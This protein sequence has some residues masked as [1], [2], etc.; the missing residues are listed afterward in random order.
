M[1]NKE[2]YI[3]RGISGSGK[4]TFCVNHLQPEVVCCSADSYF[5]D[6]AGEYRFNPAKLGEAHAYCMHSFINELARGNSVCVDNTNCS[7]WEYMNYERMAQL[8]GYNILI[9]EFR[10]ASMRD[11][12][13]CFSRNS[14]GVPLDTVL[15]QWYNLSR[16]LQADARVYPV[17]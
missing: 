8:E 13:K 17:K 11:V 16:S 7:S 2:C 5:Y 9:I 3:L 6:E 10:C 12:Q 15:R 4:S 1:S 14:H